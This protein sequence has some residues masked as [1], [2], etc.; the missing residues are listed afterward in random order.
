MNDDWRVQVTCPTTTTAANLGEQL[1]EG[2]SAHLVRFLDHEFDGRT[3]RS[4][5]G[6]IRPADHL[7]GELKSHGCSSPAIEF[8]LPGTFGGLLR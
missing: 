7:L 2:G 5:N 4:F 1:R 6:E 8:D 3:G